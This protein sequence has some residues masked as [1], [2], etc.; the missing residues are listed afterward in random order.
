MKA[1]GCSDSFTNIDFN[2]CIKDL[3]NNFHAD[4][5]VDDILFS[6]QFYPEATAATGAQLE[7]AN[8]RCKYF[9]KSGYEIQ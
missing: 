8:M 5:L 4:I 3:G 1:V 2:G 9:C 7:T 6:D